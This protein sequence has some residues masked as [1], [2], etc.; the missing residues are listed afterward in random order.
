MVIGEDC[1][2]YGDLTAFM[3]GGCIRIFNERGGFKIFSLD[4]QACSFKFGK[5]NSS[6]TSVGVAIRYA[7]GF[8]TSLAAFLVYSNFTPAVSPRV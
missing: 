3:M 8:S 1:R 6:A 5:P 7:I 2:I 4:C